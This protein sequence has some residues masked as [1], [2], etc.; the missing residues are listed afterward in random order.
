MLGR[1]RR[2]TCRDCRRRDKEKAVAPRRRDYLSYND[3]DGGL[4]GYLS[5]AEEYGR[6]N[7]PYRHRADCL[8]GS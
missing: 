4:Q 8:V 3:C 2:G 6:A 5:R 1:H 7:A